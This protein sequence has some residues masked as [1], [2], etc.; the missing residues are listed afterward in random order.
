[1]LTYLYFSLFYNDK[2][3][4]HENKSSRK[5]HREPICEI[6]FTRNVKKMTHENKSTQTFLSLRY[7][8][9]ANLKMT[10][11]GFECCYVG[12]KCCLYVCN[13]NTM[14]LTFSRSVC[15]LLIDQIRQMFYIH[16]MDR[17]FW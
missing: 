17:F 2:T 5:I 14:Q 13:S 15:H 16:Y 1:M 11:K 6:K 9:L 12:F 7:R 3:N 4:I 8:V 10:H